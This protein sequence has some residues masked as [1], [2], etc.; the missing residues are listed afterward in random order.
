MSLLSADTASVCLPTSC[1]PPTL[2]EDLFWPLPPRAQPPNA[3]L[4]SVCV[5][6]PWDSTEWGHE[7]FLGVFHP[8]HSL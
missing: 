4:A 1:S 6:F 8:R 5:A 3:P 2:I 7:V